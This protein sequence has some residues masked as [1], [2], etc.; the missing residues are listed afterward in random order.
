M[1]CIRNVNFNIGRSHTNLRANEVDDLRTSV[2]VQ[3]A[4]CG[5]DLMIHRD[6]RLRYYRRKSVADFESHV[7]V[8]RACSALASLCQPRLAVLVG[9]T[10][11]ASKVQD[12][13]KAGLISQQSAR[14][15]DL[16][17]WT[18]FILCSKPRITWQ[19]RSLADD[20]RLESCVLLPCGPCTPPNSQ[21]NGLPC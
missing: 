15:L 14:R 6:F 11:T 16:S 12:G 2:R 10:V 13:L 18:I 4:T 5:R 3:V 7:L 20:T 19:V 17:S 1:Y 9:A 8:S 21:S